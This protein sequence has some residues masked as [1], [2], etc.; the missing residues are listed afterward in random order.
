VLK[1]FSDY[2]SQIVTRVASGGHNTPEVLS[3]LVSPKPEK[4]GI[5]LSWT[6]LDRFIPRND[7]YVEL[8][9]YAKIID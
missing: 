1:N 3:L 7:N 2:S 4:R 8:I 9:K 6:I 5:Y